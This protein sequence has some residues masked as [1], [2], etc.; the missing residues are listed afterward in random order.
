MANDGWLTPQEIMARSAPSIL[1]PELI[2]KLEQWEAIK[3]KLADLQQVQIEEMRLRKE[4]A[5][6]GWKK[7]E[8][9]TNRAAL[10]NG[11]ELKLVH[12]VSYKLDKQEKVEEALDQIAKIGNE[13]SF[14]ADRLVKWEA[15]LVLDEYRKLCS[16]DATA[17]QKQIKKL[18][19]GVLTIT[20][21]APTLEIV[22]P[23]RK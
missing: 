8:E 17:Q 10:D 21:G 2:A 22:P 3:K 15:S 12:K 4:C 7:P 9:G 13:G 23:K 16:N 20:P 19:D 6:L 18:I 14:I 11:F 5:A 1:T